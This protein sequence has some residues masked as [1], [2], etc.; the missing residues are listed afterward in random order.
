LRYKS[1]TEYIF[2]SKEKWEVFIQAM[3]TRAGFSPKD[4]KY[5]HAGRNFYRHLQHRAQ[6]ISVQDDILEAK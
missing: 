6:I 3:A 4:M 1:D 2:F 5:T